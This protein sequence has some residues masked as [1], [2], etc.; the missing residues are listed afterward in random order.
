MLRTLGPKNRLLM[1][2]LFVWASSVGLWYNQR[3]LYLS[4]LGASPKQIGTALALESVCAALLLIPA[5][6]LSDRIG[7]RR[8][9]LG[10][11]S[12][13]IF[14]VMLMAMARSWQAAIPGLVIYRLAAASAPALL[15][16]ALLNIPDRR[17]PLISEKTLTTVFTAWPAAHILSPWLG[18]IIA[19][20]TSIRT[21]LWV[22]VGVFA[23]GIGLML[24]TKPVAPGWFANRQSPLELF[25]NRRFLLLVGYFALATIAMFV[26]QLL[27]PNFLHEMRGFSLA[28][29]GVLFSIFSV[30][31][32]ACNLV[33]GRSRPKWTFVGLLAVIW[34][35]YYALLQTTGVGP[36]VVGLFLLGAIS[37]TWVVMSAGIS[38]VVKERNQG[39]AFGV[40]ESLI[41]GASA[42]A[43]WLAGQLYGLTPARTLPLLAALAGVSVMLVLWFLLRLGPLVASSG[44]PEQEPG[45]CA[46]PEPLPG[47]D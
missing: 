23:L 14:G 28:T 8:V 17:V 47:D 21:T 13:G 45:T 25:R 12:M 4:E 9:I 24:L 18:G 32:V 41:M 33:V 19:Q 31:A 46:L 7:P 36:A 37:S 40:M 35:A 6:L 1:L 20:Q 38:R 27:L 3:Q 5:G 2:S 15:S 34:L 10:S 16:F 22:A 44:M 39:Q 11:W 42:V 43:A 30:G 29:I 26:G